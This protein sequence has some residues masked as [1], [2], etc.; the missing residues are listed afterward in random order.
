MFGDLVRPLNVSRGLSAIAEL[1]HNTFTVRHNIKYV[2]KH[3]LKIPPNLKRVA[4]QH[5]ER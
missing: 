4:T 3:A 1:L 5:R 2:T